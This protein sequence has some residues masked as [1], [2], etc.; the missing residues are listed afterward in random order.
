M[1]ATLSKDGHHCI[2]LGAF[3][4]DLFVRR[5]RNDKVTVFSP[6][7]LDKRRYAYP[8]FQRL[9]WADSL[10]DTCIFLADP[11][12]RI[13]TTQIGW[14]AGDS[15]TH[16]LP[17]V[18]QCIRAMTQG[19]GIAARNVRFFGSSAGG[20][21]SIA[22]ASHFEGSTALAVNPQ[23][24]CFRLHDPGE[25]SATLSSCFGTTAIPL[26]RDRVGDRLVLTEVFRKTG[27]V[28]PMT[29]WQN[30]H[31]TYHY[32]HHLVPFLQGLADFP[33]CSGAEVIVGSLKD[34]GHNPPGLDVLLPYLRR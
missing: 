6:G 30:F 13:G 9:T 15:T 7:F 10:E 19:A 18:A 27:V 11:T 16:Y 1:E 20:F 12:V 24:D 5:G 28:P 3:S 4:L 33:A 22:F 26:L 17:A 21:S 29:I 32:T 23:T 8:Y 14:F 25:L 2:D 31:D 34:L